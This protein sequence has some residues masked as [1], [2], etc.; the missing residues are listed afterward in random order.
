MNWKW[1]SQIELLSDTCALV[2]YD[3]FI[4]KNV[5]DLVNALYV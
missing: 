5:G 4:T 1:N 3:E 2:C